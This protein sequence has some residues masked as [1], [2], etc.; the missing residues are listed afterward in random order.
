MIWNKVNWE[1][2]DPGLP[3][4]NCDVLCRCISPGENGRPYVS[5]EV[6]AVASYLTKGGFMCDDRIITHWARID[7]PEDVVDEY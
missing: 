5:Y 7:G 6:Q 1:R 3:H 4:C 2:K